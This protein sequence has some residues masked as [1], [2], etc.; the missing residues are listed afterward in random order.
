MG[1]I[2]DLADAITRQE[3][4]APG[5]RAWRNNNPGNLREPTGKLYPNLPRDEQ[6]F[7][8]FPDPESGRLALERDLAVKINRGWDL[9]R[10]ITAWAPPSENATGAYIDNVSSWLGIPA[11]V[12]LMS[13]NSTSDDGAAAAEWILSPDPADWRPWAIGALAIAAV[14]LAWSD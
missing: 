12:S 9:R 2:Q 3:G 14:A 5:T 1:L 7:I 6:G 13:L 8:I 4:Y 10:L 11:D